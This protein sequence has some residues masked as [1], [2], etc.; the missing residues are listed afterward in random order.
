MSNFVRDNHARRRYELDVA[1]GQAFIDYRRDGG[2]VT[3]LHAEVPEALQGRGVG[4]AL[5]KGALDLAREQGERVIPA[6]PFVAAYIRRHAEYR[7]LI[8]ASR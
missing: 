3:M 8:A 4:S 1:G 6:C 7:D 2:V 5:V